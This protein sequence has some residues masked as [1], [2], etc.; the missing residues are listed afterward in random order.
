MYTEPD[1]AQARVRPPLTKRL[2]LRHWVALDCL[3]AVPVALT[4]YVT[5]HRDFNG[6]SG[7]PIIVVLALAAAF[8]V[9][10]RRCG[11]CWRSPSCWAYPCWCSWR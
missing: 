7:P 5:L 2:K 3:V 1:G 8:P 10:L 9:A 11:R 6:M 4:M